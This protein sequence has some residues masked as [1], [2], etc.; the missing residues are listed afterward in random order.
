MRLRYALPLLGLLAL[1]GIP[2][3]F[4]G[5]VRPVAPE[6]PVNLRIE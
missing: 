6:P 2:Q 5:E 4:A 1:A 3:A